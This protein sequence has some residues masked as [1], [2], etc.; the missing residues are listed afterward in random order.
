MSEK[1]TRHTSKSFHQPAL[2]GAALILLS[3]SYL[4]PHR[5]SV[6]AVF[7]AAGNMAS[8][9][10]E[11]IEPR[12]ANTTTDIPVTQNGTDETH[13]VLE[14][15]CPFDFRRR[16]E[17]LFKASSNIWDWYLEDEVFKNWTKGRPWQLRCYGMPRSGKVSE[18]GHSSV[19]SLL[20]LPHRPISRQ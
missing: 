1:Y 6:P 7:L 17:T 4:V 8:A 14:W 16:Q 12:P 5:Q 20:R 19:E 10:P 3:A 2:R 18:H 15:L 13:A 9:T 11:E